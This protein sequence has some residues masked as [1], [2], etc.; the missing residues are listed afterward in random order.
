MR[1][2]EIALHTASLACCVALGASL[3][4]LQSRVAALPPPAPP[5]ALPELK[6]ALREISSLKREMADLR[7]ARV[8][9]PLPPEGRPA[10]PAAE[11]SRASAAAPVTAASLA[12]ALEDPAVQKRVTELVDARLKAER[13]EEEKAQED[14]RKEGAKF[15]LDRQAENLSKE[16]ELNDF[17]KGELGKALSDLRERLD[18]LRARVRAK[19]LTTEQARAEMEKSYAEMDLKLQ[20]SLSADQFK[21]FQDE[22]RPIREMSLRFGMGGGRR[23]PGGGP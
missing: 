17:Q 21:K 11:S 16:L 10:A 1:P 19:E 22:T 9:Q 14:R 13:E 12:A 20:S 6:E 15:W 4:T 5:S 3:W 7:E 8:V 23:G 18:G 2:L